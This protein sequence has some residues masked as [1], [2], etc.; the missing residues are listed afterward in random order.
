M[1]IFMEHPEIKGEVADSQH[2]GWIDIDDVSF[3]TRRRITS[4]PATRNDRE[5]ANAEITDLMLSRRVDSATPYLFV[6]SCCG[7][8]QTVTIKLTKTGNGVGSDTYMTYTL[9]NALVSSYEVDAHAQANVRPTEL[10]TLSFVEMELKYTPYD[11][12]G[13]AKAPIAVAFNIATN[14][15]G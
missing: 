9:K 3:S 2:R 6:A 12:D 15:R 14:E 1:S 11:D 10:L 8:G 13:N 7:N 4:D 5:S